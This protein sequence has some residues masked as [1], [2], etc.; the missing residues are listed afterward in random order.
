MINYFRSMSIII[1]Q[2]YRYFWFIRTYFWRFLVIINCF[3]MILEIYITLIIIINHSW[4]D[5][6]C[7]SIFP[8]NI[9]M[10]FP[11]CFLFSIFS[12]SLTFLVTISTFH[13]KTK[14]MKNAQKNNID[15]YERMTCFWKLIKLY[16]KSKRVTIELQD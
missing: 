10:I 1:S 8:Q 12:C 5:I 11:S 13:V 2:M 15:Q 16:G 9:L 4:V 14:I 7:V 6:S 3:I